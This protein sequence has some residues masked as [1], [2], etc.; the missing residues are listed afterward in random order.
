VKTDSPQSS[1]PQH[2]QNRVP[3][4][5]CVITAVI[6]DLLPKE[7]EEPWQFHGISNLVKADALCTLKFYLMFSRLGAKRDKFSPKINL[8]VTSRGTTLLDALD[9]YVEVRSCLVCRPEF[10]PGFPH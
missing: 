8:R 6:Q 3:R 9:A 7:E 10:T 2:G 5:F 1:P 4:S